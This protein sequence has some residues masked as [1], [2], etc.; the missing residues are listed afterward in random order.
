[1][2]EYSFRGNVW[3][4]CFFLYMIALLSSPAL[5]G[6]ELDPDTL[7]FSPKAVGTYNP[8]GVL[9]RMTSWSE[10]LLDHVGNPYKDGNAIQIIAD[11]GNGIQD[12]PRPDGYPGG[13]DSL[14]NGN[15]N[16]QYVNGEKHMAEGL[17]P[18]MFMGM[19]YFIPYEIEHAVYLRLWEG[20]DPASAEYYRDSAEYTTSSGDRGGCMITLHPEYLDELDWRFGPFLK[21]IRKK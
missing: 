6:Q 21:A 12:P 18:G 4:R 13:D 5:V 8:Y 14:A 15:F 9:C 10:P 17:V 2:L 19:A 3:R 1:M 11:G 7:F 20:S 16:V